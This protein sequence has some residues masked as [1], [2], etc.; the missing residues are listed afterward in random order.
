MTGEIEKVGVIGLG[1]MG[2]GIV[3]VFARAGLD[4]VG[5]DGTPELAQ[6]GR[7]FL[8]ASTGRAVTRGRLSEQDQ[9]Q[10]LDRVTWTDSYDALAECDL[11]IEAVPERMDL[12]SAIFEALDGV[13]R[14]DAVLAT[15]TS[16]LSLTAIAAPTAHPE[17]V[18]G[19]HFFNPAPV[20]KLV[21]VIT[22]VLS[23]QGVVARVHSLAQRLGKEPVVVRDR[24]GFVANAL[25]I[26]YL[27]RAIAT[28]ETGH[29][30]REDLDAAGRIGVGFPMGPLTL[31][32]LIG[33]DVVKE[34]CDVLYAAT[35][36]PSAAPPA[37]LT[38]L[39]AAGR[40]GRKTGSGFYS[41]ERPGSGVVT[42]LP[43][44][45]DAQPAQSVVVIGDS[46]RASELADR[47][48][49]GGASS[50]EWVS[51]SG[52]RDSLAGLEVV[53][54]A[55]DSSA[56]WI[57]DLVAT[58]QPGAV[59]AIAS[60]G[61]AGT[62]PVV[63][64]GV[65]MVAVRTHPATRGGEL[66]EILSSRRDASVVTLRATLTATGFT[67][68]SGRLRA[69]GVVDALLYPHLN[70]AVRMLDSGYATAGDIDTAMIAGCGYP[71]G[72][73]AMVDRLGAA[74]VAA[75]LTAMRDESGEAALT[76][77]VLL[78]EHAASG[79]PLLG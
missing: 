77:S 53:M 40:L 9:R 43:E 52:A 27:A 44:P 35:H 15:N 4:V 13:V 3:E 55:G 38:Q 31:S 65:T 16:S 37:L 48:G 54:L 64:D 5:V 50:V 23:D 68:V 76:P 39:V 36:D 19:M 73:L 47:I 41:Y 67:V 75:V 71:E 28:Y 33:L 72:L 79:A 10:I 34:V 26:T 58:M 17:R 69:G 1:T 63:P 46:A 22:T 14:P 32:D 2:A 62:V 57:R 11:V 29:V 20:L 66:A 61:S 74:Q 59:L 8:E 24:A 51:T 78:R 56:E 45:L 42:D 60:R 6:R 70:D 30:S 21:E 7:G 18:I 49:A 25:L 12:K